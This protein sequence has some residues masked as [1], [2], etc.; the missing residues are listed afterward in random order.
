MT[1]S[2]RAVENNLFQVARSL[3]VIL[4]S[5]RRRRR[6]PPPH[7]FMDLHGSTWWIL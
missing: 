1:S 4:V 2:E 5:R 7:P 3:E 6:R